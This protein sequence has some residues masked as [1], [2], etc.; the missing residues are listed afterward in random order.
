MVVDSRPNVGEGARQPEPLRRKDACRVDLAGGD[1]W[2]AAA[3]QS[4]IMPHR[5]GA[6]QGIRPKTGQIAR[7]QRDAA[8]PP[9]VIASALVA[10]AVPPD[11]AGARCKSV[12]FRQTCYSSEIS[13][14]LRRLS[15]TQP[16]RSM[17][18]KHFVQ[19]YMGGGASSNSVAED[20]EMRCFAM[21]GVLSLGGI[22]TPG[23]FAQQAPGSTQPLVQPLP[24]TAVV[25]PAAVGPT[26]LSPPAATPNSNV[27]AVATMPVATTASGSL[28][29]AETG[30]SSMPMGRFATPLGRSQNRGPC[31]PGCCGLQGACSPPLAYPANHASQPA[32]PAYNAN[33]VGAGAYNPSSPGMAQPASYI[34]PPGYP[35]ASSV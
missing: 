21:A 5:R 27:P 23:L 12:N 7:I 4:P 19:S 22:M 18:P 9:A 34:T 10:A 1:G 2:A 17:G 31:G 16:L 8:G 32:T 25:S 20:E 15:P 11:P 24:P 35:A 29:T 30:T 28:P 26:T 14:D 3:T 33:A 6:R 13:G